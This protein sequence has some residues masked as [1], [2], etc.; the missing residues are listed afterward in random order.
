MQLDWRSGGDIYSSSRQLQDISRTSPDFDEPSPDGTGSLGNYRLRGRSFR[1]DSIGIY[2]QSASAVR[3]RE[4]VLRYSVPPVVARR[5]L[6][7]SSL[8]ISVQARNLA[9][10]SDS[11]APDPEFSGLGR[12]ALCVTWTSRGIRRCGR[13]SLASISVSEPRQ[14]RY[15][16]IDAELLFPHALPAL[17][18]P[19]GAGDPTN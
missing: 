7:A 17:E 13:S 14:S 5:V 18:R 19:D 9:L 3:I 4:A 11:W 12:A 1:H 10:W 16:R 8:G 2:V 6:G 15:F